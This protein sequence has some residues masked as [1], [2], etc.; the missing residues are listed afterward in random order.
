MLEGQKAVI[1]G[2]DFES[3]GEQIERRKAELKRAAQ[4]AEAK[5]V[6]FSD[7]LI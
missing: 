4:S 2:I 7:Y 3:T 5:L 6:K 1:Q